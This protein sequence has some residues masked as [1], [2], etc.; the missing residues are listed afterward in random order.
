MDNLKNIF[1]EK[2]YN[3][4]KKTTTVAALYLAAHPLNI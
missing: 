3:L 4:K 1:S 2:S